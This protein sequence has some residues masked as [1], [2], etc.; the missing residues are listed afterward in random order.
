MGWPLSLNSQRR[1]GALAH[2]RVFYS[3]S[4]PVF[5]AYHSPST[6]ERHCHR[7]VSS[8]VA[9]RLRHASLCSGNLDHFNATLRPH[10]FRRYYGGMQVQAYL[11][12]R[13][14]TALHQ[15]GRRSGSAPRPPRP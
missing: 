1:A 8:L 9:H 4:S 11:V 15:P 7:S 5:A 12:F 2:L 10:C 13:S 6:L 14:I 3:C